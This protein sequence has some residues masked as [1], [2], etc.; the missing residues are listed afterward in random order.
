MPSGASISANALTLRNFAAELMCTPSSAPTHPKTRMP[1]MVYA[2]MNPVWHKLLPATAFILPPIRAQVH[3]YIDVVLSQ[4]SRV[5]NSFRK[6][7]AE[8]SFCLQNRV[9]SSE[10]STARKLI[11]ELHAL[12]AM[13]RNPVSQRCEF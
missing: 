2:S 3:C 6:S 10:A 7:A 5:H 9:G 4:M 13:N 12:L 11:P 1:T 8:V